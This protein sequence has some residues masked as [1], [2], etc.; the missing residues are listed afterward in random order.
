MVRFRS[1]AGTDD[2][3][4]DRGMKTVNKTY[5]RIDLIQSLC[6][7]QYSFNVMKDDALKNISILF[8]RN[9]RCCHQVETINVNTI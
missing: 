9:G 5:V 7:R 4:Q 1:E 6:K 3:F 8:Q 2:R